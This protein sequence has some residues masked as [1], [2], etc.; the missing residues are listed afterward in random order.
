MTIVLNMKIGSIDVDAAIDNV[1]KLLEQDEKISN[2]LKA[3]ISVLLILVKALTNRLGLNS[4]NSSK[5]PST[6]DTLTS[7]FGSYKKFQPRP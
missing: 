7:S 1:Q 4:K 3:A 5:P 2:G 6:D